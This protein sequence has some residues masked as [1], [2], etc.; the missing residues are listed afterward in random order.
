MSFAAR[1]QGYSLGEALPLFQNSRT[2]SASDVAIKGSAIAYVL[3]N[4]NSTGTV[5]V[6][7]TPGGGAS[8]GIA[9]GEWVN[10]LTASDWQIKLDKTSGSNPTAGP[11]LATWHNLTT[12]R[13]WEMYINSVAGQ[14]VSGTFSVSFKKTTD[15][16]ARITYTGLTLTASIF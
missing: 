15:S 2:V 14:S 5:T 12:T 9:A 16:V 3:L 7:A 6:T 13:Q 11:A 4:F 8:P 1:V 10:G